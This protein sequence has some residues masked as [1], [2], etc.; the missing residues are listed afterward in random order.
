MVSPPSSEKPRS[1]AEIREITGPLPPAAER[2]I[3]GS[4][5]PAA[6]LAKL[7][8]GDQLG[9]AVNYLAASLDCRA[10]TWWACLC[11][12]HSERFQP[13]AKNAAAITRALHWVIDPTDANRHEAQQAFDAAG[14]KLPGGCAALVAHFAGVESASA[15]ADQRKSVR[16]SVARAAAGTALLAAAAAKGEFDGDPVR[17]Y[18]AI[19]IDVANG[20]NRWESN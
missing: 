19:G 6:A 9:D 10:A 16:R 5:E 14:S 18:L 7:I 15:S 1:V 8:D 4:A 11:A 3:M 13:S 20:T 2:L 12:Q 17:Q